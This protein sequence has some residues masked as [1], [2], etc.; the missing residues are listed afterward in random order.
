MEASTY[1]DRCC[2]FL[3]GRE[4]VRADRDLRTDALFIRTENA[5]GARSAQN[6]Q[7]SIF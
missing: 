1:F 3:R 5:V 4:I 2:A 7:C 6:Y